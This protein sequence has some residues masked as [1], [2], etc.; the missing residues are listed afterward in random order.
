MNIHRH[1]R[2]QNKWLKSGCLRQ[3]TCSAIEKWPVARANM[4]MFSLFRFAAVSL[5]P[6]I[7]VRRSKTENNIIRIM[8][9]MF[10]LRYS[11]RPQCISEHKFSVTVRLYYSTRR[12]LQASGC[13]H[14]ITKGPY[15]CRCCFLLLSAIFQFLKLARLRLNQNDFDIY[16]FQNEHHSFHFPLLF[17]AWF[18]VSA[19]TFWE[20]AMRRGPIGA[21][22]GGN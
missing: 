12:V 10:R 17:S 8:F 1:R 9:T 13:E 5:D 15:Y 16:C 2:R 7:P 6:F 11:V 18:F 19:R 20:L 3:L 4:L 14:R 21:T 22:R